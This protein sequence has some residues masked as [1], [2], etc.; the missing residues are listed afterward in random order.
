MIVK[1]GVHHMLYGA[2]MTE[3]PETA[4][5]CLATS[6]DGRDFT[7][8]KNTDGY[9]R[10][11]QGPAESRDPMAVKIGELYS[12]LLHGPRR[13]QT[14]A[15]QDLLPDLARPHRMVGPSGT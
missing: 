8:Y 7:R 13:G 4:R 1:D 5:V 9:S 11:F 6:P 10:V 12:L 15:L 3:M 14:R 2:H